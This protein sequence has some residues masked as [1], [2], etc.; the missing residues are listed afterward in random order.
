MGI[1]TIHEVKGL[2]FDN[3]FVIGLTNQDV[4]DADLELN[5]ALPA[6]Y[7]FDEFK[8]K[9]NKL[10]VTKDEQLKDIITKLYSAGVQDSS[11]LY[12][13]FQLQGYDCFPRT[14]RELKI[15]YHSYSQLLQNLEEERRLIYVAITRAKKRCYVEK[16]SDYLESSLIDELEENINFQ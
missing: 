8:E 11:E 12:M 15:I 2:E 3:V 1:Y 10:A 6:D 5:K 4:D 9:I 14:D 7:S 16:V 13:S